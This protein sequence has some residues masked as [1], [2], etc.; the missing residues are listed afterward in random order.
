[1]PA[2]RIPCPRAEDGRAL[3]RILIDTRDIDRLIESWKEVNNADMTARPVTVRYVPRLRGP[4]AAR[5]E[6]H[7]AEAGEQSTSESEEPRAPASPSAS[8]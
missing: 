5:C 7:L 6:V 2:L 1:M 4:A 3:R 8:P